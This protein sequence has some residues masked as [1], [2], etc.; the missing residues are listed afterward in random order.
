MNELI[1]RLEQ[2]GARLV[3]WLR[4][5]NAS[6]LTWKPS[7]SGW[8]MLEVVGHLCD[9][10]RDD[11]RARVQFMLE[12][13]SPWPPIDPEGSVVANGWQGREPAAAINEFEAERRASLLWLRQLDRPDWTK[14]YEHHEVGTITAAD[15]LASWVAHDLLHGRQL[16]RLQAD[17]F[18]HSIAP[19]SASYADPDA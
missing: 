1:L 3:D 9:E 17:A 4:R 13:V 16:A 15:L 14:S 10:E 11:F 5:A 12:G 18:R 2:E 8:S 7:A 6:E 19:L